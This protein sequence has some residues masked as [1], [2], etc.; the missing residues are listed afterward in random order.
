MVDLLETSRKFLLGTTV[1]DVNLVSTHALCAAGSVHGYVAAAD[2]RDLLR[3]VDRGV[4]VFLVCLHQID[5][6]QVLVRRVNA[7]RV[8]ARHADKGRQ[9]GAGTDENRF[10]TVAEQLVDGLR[11]ADNEVQNKLN[12]EVLQRV[13]LLLH[14]GLRQTELRNAVHQNAAG[15]VQCLENGNFV[16][17]AS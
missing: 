16:T 10:K 8:L 13:D 2:D 17:H 9:T 5:A 11:T 1:H 6:G 4:C 14:D 12:T 15:G 7:V 3:V